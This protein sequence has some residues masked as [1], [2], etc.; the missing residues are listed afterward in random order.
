MTRISGGLSEVRFTKVGIIC[1]WNPLTREYRRIRDPPRDDAHLIGYGFGYDC[2]NDDYKLVRLLHGS[3]AEVYT[4]GSDSWNQYQCPFV[5][6]SAPT[7]YYGVRLNGALHWKAKKIIV[8]FDVSD[9]IF[10][11]F[12]LPEQPL[13]DGGGVELG[14]LESCLCLVSYSTSGRF[15]IWVMQDYGV[16]DSLD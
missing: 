12:P 14:I 13:D 2:Q 10:K 1:L 16:K 6:A 11:E 5:F 9:E 8:S 7:E 15:D 3:E 4:F